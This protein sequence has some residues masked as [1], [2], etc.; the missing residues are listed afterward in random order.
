MRFAPLLKTPQL[1]SSIYLP[2]FFLFP[3]HSPFLSTQLS[4]PFTSG[5]LLLF[6]FPHA[7]V[8]MEPPLF[9][10]LWL[11]TSADTG[12][13]SSSG[14]GVILLPSP[15][16]LPVSSPPF[17]PSPLPPASPAPSPPHPRP[18]PRR[19]SSLSPV[20][21]LTNHFKGSRTLKDKTKLQHMVQSPD[22]CLSPSL[23][24]PPL[25]SRGS[26]GSPA[27]CRLLRAPRA[28]LHPPP[29]LPSSALRSSLIFLYV[30]CFPG[31][32]F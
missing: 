31:L 15:R 10:S 32:L 24:P 4:F 19:T 17:P 7:A 29:P 22:V 21:R 26:F 30:F 3:F 13:F 9:P 27:R 16:L 18:A 23:A 8:W 14:A 28:A 25:P 2:V 5:S 11:R 12:V 6:F 1:L 20:G